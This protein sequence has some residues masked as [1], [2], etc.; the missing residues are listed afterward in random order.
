MLLAASAAILLI[1]SKLSPTSA[2]APAIYTRITSQQIRSD[3]QYTY[4]YLYLY[5]IREVLLNL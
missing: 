1:S 4:I 2:K 3:Y 5:I